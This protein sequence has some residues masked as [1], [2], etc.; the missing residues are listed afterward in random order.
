[1]A[2]L[3]PEEPKAKSVTQQPTLDKQ[4]TSPTASPDCQAK[5]SQS[6]EIHWKNKINLHYK[7]AMLKLCAPFSKSSKGPN[8]PDIWEWRQGRPDGHAGIR[9]RQKQTEEKRDA[10]L[11]QQGKVAAFLL[12]IMNLFSLPTWKC[13]SFIFF[14]CFCLTLPRLEPTQRTRTRLDEILENLNSPRAA[15]QPLGRR[16]E[17]PPPSQEKQQKEKTPGVKTDA[18]VAQQQSRVL[19]EWKTM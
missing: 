5:T 6:F 18:N 1:M 17:E 4:S 9:Q 16:R 3:L 19:I 10:T 7:R 14:L 15:D 13:L 8:R 2:D 11:V 12:F